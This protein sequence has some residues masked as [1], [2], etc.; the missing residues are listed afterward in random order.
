MSTITDKNKF[1]S[2]YVDKISYSKFQTICKIQGLSAN[3]VIN[4]MIKEYIAKNTVLLNSQCEIDF[5]S[6]GQSIE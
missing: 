4:M 1:I 3:K 2:A 6:I 5:F